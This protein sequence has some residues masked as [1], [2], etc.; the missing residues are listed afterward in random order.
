MSESELLDAFEPWVQ[1]KMPSNWPVAV[2]SYLSTSQFFSRTTG[3]QY[4][5]AE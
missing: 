4:Y 2:K 5:L 1:G 3:G